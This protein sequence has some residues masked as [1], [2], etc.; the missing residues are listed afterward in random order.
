MKSSK[1]PLL[2]TM[3]KFLYKYRYAPQSTIGKFPAELML[4][5]KMRS[6]LDLL[7]P[8]EEIQ[9]KVLKQEESQKRYHTSK[10]RTVSLNELEPAMAR[11][12]SYY[13][14]KRVPVEP[15]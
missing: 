15:V 13:G 4:G 14:P 10:P 7:W 8:W 12:Y 9:G 11:N 2:L 3:G 5:R 1:G 6:R